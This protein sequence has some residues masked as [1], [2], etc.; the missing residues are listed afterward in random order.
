[1]EASTVSVRNEN[2][3]GPQHVKAGAVAAKLGNRYVFSAMFQ[4][5]IVNASDLNL[6][7][8]RG[9]MLWDG[10]EA[11]DNVDGTSQNYLQ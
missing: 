7:S 5:A 6:D 11:L 4:A 9:W 2:N 10:S 8:F 1:M 3:I